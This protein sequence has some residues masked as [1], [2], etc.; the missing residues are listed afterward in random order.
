M[1][2]GDISMQSIDSVDVFGTWFSPSFHVLRLTWIVAADSIIPSESSIL[3]A[4]QKRERLRTTGTSNEEDFISLSVI[5][6]SDES[7]G[8]HPESRLMREE[9]ELGEGD[10][11]M[12]KPITFGSD[13]H[14]IPEFAEYTSAQERV[15]LGKKSKKAAA[16]KRKEAMQEM[17]EDAC[18]S[19]LIRF[20]QSSVN[21]HFRAEEDEETKEWEQEQ[22]RRGGHLGDESF[23]QAPVKQVYK[24]APSKSVV[25]P[26][27]IHTNTPRTLL[28]P[29]SSAIPSLGS[30]I[31]RLTQSLT[32]LTTS[33]ASN[34]AAMSS[35]A[36]E[37]EELDKKEM[38]MREMVRKAEAKKSWF[39][40]FNEWVENVAT[41]LD[42]K[43]RPVSPLFLYGQ[44]LG[45]DYRSYDSVPAARET[46][47]RA[48][49][50][51]KRAVGDDFAPPSRRR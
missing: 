36:E 44:V 34:T 26:Q 39:V 10:D 25:G 27:S 14:L 6:R 45:I 18:V 3:N 50:D 12:F 29:T 46:R 32:A 2:I 43:V 42:E 15:P 31:A 13:S 11:G 48:R 30:A 23:D 28:V 4:K 24:P 1:E 51:L 5:R 20:N 47:R 8:P 37:R 38:E 7:K 19:M 49:I 9:D 40:A 17:I 41:F 22:L 21:R 16:G 35:L 33:H